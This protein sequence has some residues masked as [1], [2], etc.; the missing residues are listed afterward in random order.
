[1]WGRLESKRSQEAE[2]FIGGPPA[3]PNRILGAF[4]LML[5]QGAFTEILEE[6]Y[7]KGFP[8]PRIT[9]RSLI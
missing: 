5:A 6:P 2:E 1:M 4:L 3:V 9:S 7:Y 8:L